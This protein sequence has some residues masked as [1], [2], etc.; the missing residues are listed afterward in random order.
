MALLIRLVPLLRR[1]LGQSEATASQRCYGTGEGEGLET[2]RRRLVWHSTK[3]GTVENELILGSFAKKNLPQ[4][5]EDSLTAFDLIL[6]ESDPDLFKWLTKPDEEPPAEFL[7]SH[8]Q[9]PDVFSALRA[10]VQ[11]GDSAPPATINRS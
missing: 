10:H 2:Q 7:S 3:R 5:S 4:F 6:Q 9:I 11:S 8:P 1:D